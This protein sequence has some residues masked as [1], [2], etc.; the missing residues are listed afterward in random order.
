MGMNP[1]V[2]VWYIYIS[3]HVRVSF[4]SSPICPC[5]K[6]EI[7]EAQQQMDT[8]RNSAGHYNLISF[9]ARSLLNCLCN[10]VQ[11]K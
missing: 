4:T 9:L 8:D 10:S 3:Y 7:L 6:I 1:S 11:P 5:R 2:P